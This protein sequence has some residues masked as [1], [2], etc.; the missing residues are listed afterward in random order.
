MGV[1]KKIE[2]LHLHNI[3]WSISEIH[4]LM[5]SLSIN[6]LIRLDISS[7]CQ[8]N[9]NHQISTINS[10]SRVIH[11]AI[12]VSMPITTL[13]ALLIGMRRVDQ[14][15][16]FDDCNVTDIPNDAPPKVKQVKK[17]QY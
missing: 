12:H 13:M 8:L 4:H 1:S 15:S 3:R 10:P 11:V 17:Q 5:Y 6:L 14:L 9:N 2:E 16:F 7:C